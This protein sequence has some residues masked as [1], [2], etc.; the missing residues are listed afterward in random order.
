M[1]FIGPG[2]LPG[3][4]TAELASPDAPSPNFTGP[5]PS[6]N[7][8]RDQILQ[9]FSNSST[10]RNLDY[11]THLSQIS[12]TDDS[13]ILR[14]IGGATQLGREGNYGPAAGSRSG[15]FLDRL[16]LN[17]IRELFHKFVV[18]PSLISRSA[19]GRRTFYSFDQ[20]LNEVM[21][22]SKWS[23]IR[24]ARNGDFERTFFA[25]VGNSIEKLI[26][27]AEKG[28]EDPTLVV[29]IQSV[30]T[31]GSGKPKSLHGRL[32]K[33]EFNEI[34]AD[35]HRRTKLAA[36]Y[37]GAKRV[38]GIPQRLRDAIEAELA[39]VGIEAGGYS[40]AAFSSGRFPYA[41]T[42][43]RVMG[44][45]TVL[46]FQRCESCG[47]VKALSITDGNTAHVAVGL[48]LSSQLGEWHRSVCPEAQARLQDHR[49]WMEL[50]D[51]QKRLQAQIGSAKL[52]RRES[53][54]AP[55]GKALA[56][57]YRDYSNEYIKESINSYSGGNY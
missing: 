15:V 13:D 49:A 16:S 35:H 24:Y 44:T 21:D 45:F 7:E 41:V 23:G 25:V 39:K 55:Y 37:A 51:N 52:E 29:G 46:N 32:F 36:D 38:S 47:V 50:R 31:T 26:L 33:H 34:L 17:L 12:E 27:V 22:S 40:R 10:P 5:E 18:P 9:D 6:V 42:Q 8:R 53:R 3:S 4:S 2:A 54:K 48:K 19:L 28:I 56:K 43:S 20:F 14:A 30:R 11:R 57:S 1:F